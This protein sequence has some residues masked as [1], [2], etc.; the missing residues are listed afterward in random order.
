MVATPRNAATGRGHGKVIVAGEH[1]VLHG[2]AALAMALPTLGTTVSLRPGDPASTR[3]AG[4]RI[5]T[6]ADLGAAELAS[7]AEMLHAALAGVGVSTAQ[8]VTITSEIPPGSGLGSSAAL[9]VATV[10]AAESMAGLRL[11]AAARLR[12]CRQVEALVPGRSSGLAPAAALSSGAVLFADGAVEREIEVARTPAL[13]AARWVLFDAGDAPP[14]SVAVRRCREA[15]A[16][17]PDGR[18][19]ALVAAVD[20]ATRG[21]AEALNQGDVGA[22]AGSMRVCAGALA[23]VDVTDDGMDAIIAAATAAGAL[24]V[25]QTGAGLGGMMLALAPSVRIAETVARTV[26]PLARSSR[27]VEIAQ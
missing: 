22:L 24:A 11:P 25:K 9:A 17:L 20:A 2:S 7:T 15:M 19:A 23:Q 13:R 16:A 12:I 10:H 5:R 21:A 8:A 27:L 4:L 3:E 18:A 1:F 26:R 6:D 14:T